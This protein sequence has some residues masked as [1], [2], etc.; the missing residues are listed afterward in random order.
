MCVHGCVCACVSVL[1]VCTCACVWAHGWG[2]AHTRVCHYRCVHSVH[3]APLHGCFSTGCLV[4]LTP[5][6]CSP[7]PLLPMPEQPLDPAGLDTGAPPV[8]AHWAQRKHGSQSLGPDGT[9][10]PRAGAGPG[11][12]PGGSQHPAGA[13]QCRGAGLVPTPVAPRCHGAHPHRAAKKM[14]GFWGSSGKGGT[15]LPPAPKTPGPTAQPTASC[16]GAHCS[17]APGC[18]ARF[19]CQSSAIFYSNN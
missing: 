3:A 14:G 10:A 13:G 7:C 12:G 9:A 6:P 1:H 2:V 15:E 16:A 4:L 11:T 8:L 5:C 17:A 18:G 19:L